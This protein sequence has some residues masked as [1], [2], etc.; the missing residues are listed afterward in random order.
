MEA[1]TIEQCATVCRVHAVVISKWIRDKGLKT[2]APNSDTQHTA[3]TVDRDV[4]TAFAKQH[5][6]VLRWDLLEATDDSD[7]SRRYIIV[8]TDGKTRSHRGALPPYIL[9]VYKDLVD[10]IFDVS[11]PNNLSEYT[12]ARVSEPNWCDI[13][14]LHTFENPKQK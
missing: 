1:L 7:A 4:L 6:F 5:G 10:H 13:D 12:A 3:P 14:K 11:D 2:S 9:Q 8:F